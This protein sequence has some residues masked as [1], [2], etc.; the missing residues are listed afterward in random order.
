MTTIILKLVRLFYNEKV[1]DACT[2][3]LYFFNTLNSF[4]IFSGLASL[5]FLVWYLK[6]TDVYLNPIALLTMFVSL[7]AFFIILRIADFYPTFI[8]FNLPAFILLISYAGGSI[9][10]QSLIPNIIIFALIQAIF[11]GVPDSIVG[12]NLGII[13]K[14]FLWSLITIAPTTVS[15]LISV[16]FSL[17][18]T[19]L[20]YVSQI[21]KS[22]TINLALWGLILLAGLLT[23]AVRPR[24]KYSKNFRVPHHG[25]QY[26][27]VIL[28]A[29]DGCRYDVF[30]TL[31]L[32]NLEKLASEGARFKNGLETI[33]RALTNPGFASLMTG[34]P[35]EVHGI[36]D[37]NFGQEIRVEGL[38]DIT[39]TKI[40]GSMHMKHFAK[41]EWEVKVISL[42]THSIYH[43]DDEMM[44]LLKEDLL[45]DSKTRLFVTDFSEADFLG[46][47]YGSTSE[48]YKN[49]II[50]IDRRI[51]EFVE[52][53]KLNNLAE[54]TALIVTSDHGTSEIDHS[55]KIRPGEKYVPCILWGKHLKK[56]YVYEERYSIMDIPCN[57]AY[58]LGIPYP[59]KARGRV[60]LEAFANIDAEAE[61]TKWVADMNNAF[62]SA[63]SNDYI[64]E[65][66]EIY[67]GD[68][69]WWS[70]QFHRLLSGPLKDKKINILDFG[71]GAGFV[72]QTFQGLHQLQDRVQDF[73]VYDSNKEIL[74]TAKSYLKKGYF[75]FESSFETIEKN[76]KYFDII[77]INSVLHHFYDPKTILERL[78]KLLKPGGIFIGAHEPNKR[79]FRNRIAALLA[80]LFKRLGGGK[81]FDDQKLE[82]MN[83]YLSNLYGQKLH[84]SKEEIFQ[85]AEFHSPIEQSQY[86]VDREIGFDSNVLENEFYKDFEVLELKSYTSFFHRKNLKKFPVVQKILERL[87]HS[88]FKSGNLLSYV[89]R[90]V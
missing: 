3:L 72:G 24:N 60:F 49:A 68:G 83:H 52:W 34:C 65:H 29:I 47:A 30:R 42:P 56:G 84:Y 50:R 59:N 28:L 21:P 51:G 78:K 64:E 80:S 33:Y 66:P 39:P 86:G 77:A 63:F 9:A 8:L 89:V 57:I 45:R 10:L 37:N 12:R 19:L 5:T 71:A 87:F 82:T 40:Y 23:Y 13:P 55:Y 70:H 69:Q 75:R 44:K 36:R 90:S 31:K 48:D 35:P 15:F 41:K 6:L 25:A 76:E 46:H 16:Y 18:L 88:L 53:L 20:L 54:D 43:S 81:T 22:P 11:M 67:E 74:E 27:R 17:H 7:I 73:V 61:K 38:P 62:Y 32:P 4:F 2:R 14:K 26:K 58:L 85:I 79:F 1:E